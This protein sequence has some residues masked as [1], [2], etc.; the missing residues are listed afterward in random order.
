MNLVLMAVGLLATAG[1]FVTVGFG[2]PINAFSLGNTLIISG[3]VAVVGGLVLIAL[4]VVIGHLKRIAETLRSGAPRRARPAESS[5]AP[6]TTQAAPP[7]IPARALGRLSDMPEPPLPDLH[8]FE[9]LQ[10]PRASE[11]RPPEPHFPATATEPAG[12]LDWLRAR[13]KPGAML[14]SMSEPP[15]VETRD[16]APLSPRPPQRPAMPSAPEPSLDPKLWSPPTRENMPSEPRPAPRVEMPLPRSAPQP[17]E[18]PKNERFGF[19]LVWPDR[20]GPAP[21]QPPAAPPAPTAAAPANEPVKREPPL[22]MPMPPIP[23]RP[24]ETK[25][26]EKR[27]EPPRKPAERGPAILKSGVIDGMPYTLY[28]DGSIEAQLPQGTVKFASVDALRAHLE[29]QS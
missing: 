15:M 5:P 23:A 12:P 27:P 14:P 21:A 6:R 18:P 8:G 25:P 2:I 26:A 29:K 19:D 11:P 17:I 7:P 9:H 1:G 24:R 3:T 16:E 20:G 13:S 4:A 28:A 10:A 22:D